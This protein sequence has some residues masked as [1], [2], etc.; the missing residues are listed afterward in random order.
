M[1]DKIFKPEQEKVGEKGSANINGKFYEL[2][3]KVKEW[4]LR[5]S[6]F[7]KTNQIDMKI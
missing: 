2:E 6:D 5:K 4:S 7:F 1:M 3:T